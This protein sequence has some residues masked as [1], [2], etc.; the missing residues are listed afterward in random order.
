MVRRR[1]DPQMGPKLHPTWVENGPQKAP[2]LLPGAFRAAV[3]VPG[4]PCAAQGRFLRDFWSHV[5][6]HVPPQNCPKIGRKSSSNQASLGILILEAPEAP[7]TSFWSH[8]GG[9]FGCFFGPPRWG[10]GICGNPGFLT[11]VRHLLLFFQIPWGRK[12]GK[13]GSGNSIQ[14]EPGSKSVLGGLGE[15]FWSHLGVILGP[16]NGPEEGPKTSW[17]FDCILRGSWGRRVPAIRAPPG[18]GRTAGRG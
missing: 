10:A 18:Y 3:G 2:K 7:G 5:G 17:I 15:R 11:T 9:H 16:K 1:N 4:G 6:V 14:Q 13:N 12:L 8:F